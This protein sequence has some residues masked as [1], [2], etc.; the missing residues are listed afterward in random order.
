[1]GEAK[2]RIISAGFTMFR[3]TGLHRLAAAFTRGIGA[4]LMFHQVRPWVERDFAPNRLLEIT[5]EFLDA[6][7]TRLRSL[8]FE[9]LSLDAALA[10]ME[11]PKS[12]GRPFIVLTFDDGYRDNRDHALPVL[13]KHGAPFTLYVTTG[14]AERTARLW[15][16]ELEEAIRALPHIDVDIAGTPLR[17]PSTTAAQK[18]AAFETLYHLLRERP[19]EELLD[20]IARLCAAAGVDSAAIAAALCLDWAGIEEIAR[21]PLSTIGVHTLTHPRLAKHAPDFAARELRESRQSIE[22]HIGKSAPHLA[23][24]VGDPTSAGPRE[25]AIARELGFASAVT[26]RPGMIF[27]EH[28]GR[29]CALPR[30][31]INGNWQNLDIVEILVSGAPFSLW[32]RGRLVA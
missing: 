6:V 25:F 13:E 26:T 1:M 7:L 19:E 10:R 4:I 12:D 15:W 28:A 5:P 11:A 29:T 8:G 2:N 21:H 18:Q 30:L 22:A 23:Y 32:N 17:L 16:V 27:H 31:S 9:V 3:A 24:P 20:V 14:F